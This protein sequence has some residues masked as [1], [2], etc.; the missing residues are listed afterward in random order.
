MKIYCQVPFDISL[1][2]CKVVD[3][4][5]SGE[6]VVN[7][8]SDVVEALTINSIEGEYVGEATGTLVTISQTGERQSYDVTPKGTETATVTVNAT[9]GTLIINEPTFY[10]GKGAYLGAIVRKIPAVLTDEAITFSLKDYSSMNGFYTVAGDIAGQY[11]D[12]R[13]V[14]D[15]TFLHA[16]QMIGTIHFEGIKK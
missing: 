4:R 6:D 2:P 14:L 13:L 5:R 7:Q 9:D 1:E 15:Y 3:L 11:K 16:G 8:L 12:K 10:V